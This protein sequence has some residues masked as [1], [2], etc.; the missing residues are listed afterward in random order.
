MD[1]A[2]IVK[3]VIGIQKQSFNNLMEALIFFQNHAD[4][5]VMLL[6]NQMGLNEN[7]QAFADQWRMFLIKGRDDSRELINES[8]TYM[9]DYFAGLEQKNPSKK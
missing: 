5:T 1:P 9:E 3:D 8:F 6:V 2:L 7:A 4:K